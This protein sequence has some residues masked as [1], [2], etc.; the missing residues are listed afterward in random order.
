M[1]KFYTLILILAI[2]NFPIAC[3]C[4]LDC[5]CAN[6][7]SA[8]SVISKINS[9]IGTYKLGFYSNNVDSSANNA[10]SKLRLIRLRLLNEKKK[11]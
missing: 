3:S 4:D 7:K 10:A 2:T 8:S 5:E 9:E 1:N 6:L 11:N